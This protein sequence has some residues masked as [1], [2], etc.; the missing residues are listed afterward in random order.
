MQQVYQP[1]TSDEFEMNSRRKLIA[2]NNSLGTES[3]NS[4]INIEQLPPQSSQTLN[5]TATDK[6]SYEN[7]NDISNQD[8]SNTNMQKPNSNSSLKKGSTKLKSLDRNVNEKQ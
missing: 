6:P 7:N 3:E 1:R 8:S 2:N 5:S 4:A